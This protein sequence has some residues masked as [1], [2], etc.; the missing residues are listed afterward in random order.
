VAARHA[1]FGLSTIINRCGVLAG[2]WQ[3][4]KVDQG[5]FVLWAAR[6]LYGGVLAYSGFGGAGYQVRDVLHVVDLADLICRQIDAFDR[7]S[8]Q[9]YNVG[10][11]QEVSVSLAE[12]TKLCAVRTG[13]RLQIGGDP[14]TRPADILY[15]VSDN[16]LAS[17]ATSW[18]PARSVE[19]TLDE[20]LEWLLAIAP[21]CSQCHTAAQ[22]SHDW[23]ANDPQTDFTVNANGTLNLLE[24][25]R[26][27]CPE[28]VLIFTSTNKCGGEQEFDGFV[29]KEERGDRAE[30]AGE[31]FIAAGVADAAN[32]VLPA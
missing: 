29:A 22:P 20:I 4:G 18:A 3:M 10:G 7:H 23:A 1:A 8:G 9:T 15:Y 5:F 30:S 11:G 16:A 2:P 24:A 19:T 21:N 27:H 6:H 31:R 26:R 25:T 32:D 28:A 14:V 13:R 12:L 17:K